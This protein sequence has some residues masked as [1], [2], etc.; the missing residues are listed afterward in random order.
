[1]KRLALL[2]ALALGACA[3]V[4]DGPRYTYVDVEKFLTPSATAI[5]FK[6]EGPE[7]AVVRVR[8]QAIAEV[9][10]GQSIHVGVAP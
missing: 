4:P 10:P 1:M 5:D 7:I 3:H 6:N 2:A 9:Q 8:G